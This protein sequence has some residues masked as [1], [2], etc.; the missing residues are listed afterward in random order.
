MEQPELKGASG[1]TKRGYAVQD[2]CHGT[3]RFHPA[4]IL[5]YLEAIGGILH[6]AVHPKRS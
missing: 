4:E 5:H 2:S 1:S 6:M 3:V